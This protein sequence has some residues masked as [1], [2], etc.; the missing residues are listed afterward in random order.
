M[1]KQTIGVPV[2]TLQIQMDTKLYKLQVRRTVDLKIHATV[3]EEH[4]TPYVQ[5]NVLLGS[6]KYE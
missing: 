1:S 4:N 5:L 6:L 3:V 2:H